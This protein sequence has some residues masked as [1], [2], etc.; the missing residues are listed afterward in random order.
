MVIVLQIS[1]AQLDKLNLNIFVMDLVDHVGN[2]PIYN[3]FS[4][5]LRYLICI[6]FCF[7]ILLQLISKNFN[8]H[9]F[10]KFRKYLYSTQV[11][12]ALFQNCTSDL[13]YYQLYQYIS[14]LLNLHHAKNLVKLMIISYCIIHQ[15]RYFSY[16]RHIYQNPDFL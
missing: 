14:R 6:Q 2:L 4:E 9:F 1:T 3:P 13:N 16:L 11:I 8:H 12:A 15:H 10:I 7:L 5:S